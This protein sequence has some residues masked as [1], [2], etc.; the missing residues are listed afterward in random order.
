MN[1]TLPQV[2][3]TDPK[4]ARSAGLYCATAAYNTAVRQGGDRATTLDR[5]T[6]TLTETMADVINGVTPGVDT[7]FAEALRAATIVPLR[8]FAAIEQARTELGDGYGYVLDILA[9]NVKAG[10][11]PRPIRRDALALPARL[12][13]FGEATR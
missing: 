5:I 7:D 12:R 6:D 13:E 4:T 2:P 8:A 10:A 1:A 11:D 9:H 3:E